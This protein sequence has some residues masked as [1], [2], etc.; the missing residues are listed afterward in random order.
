LIVW[1]QNDPFFTIAGAEAYTQDLKNI[2]IHLLNTGHF[3]LEEEREAI[4]Q[5]I[6]R[7]LSGEN[8]KKVRV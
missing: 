8:K 4:A 2:E 7:F 1:G 3:A 5:H 6:H